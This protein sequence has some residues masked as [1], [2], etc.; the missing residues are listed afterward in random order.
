MVARNC[1]RRSSGGGVLA[2][3]S[4]EAGDVGFH[5][6]DLALH[7]G[8]VAV[9]RVDR[10]EG[11]ERGPGE[12]N[13]S[14]QSGRH[15]H[16]GADREAAQALAVVKENIA[17]LEDVAEPGGP[18]GVGRRQS[19]HFY[20]RPAPT[21]PI[22]PPWRPLENLGFAPGSN[23]SELPPNLCGADSVKHILTR[24]PHRGDPGTNRLRPGL[25]C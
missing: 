20:P 5:L 14:G 3:L 17:R 16:A 24:Q 1:W 22:R 4:A 18:A 12:Q 11:G 9:H 10:G 19:R 6:R 8:D 23:L 15:L 13:K 2:G 7:P 25:S 21:G